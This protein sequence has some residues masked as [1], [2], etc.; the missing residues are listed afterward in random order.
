MKTRRKS[1][2]LL[3]L[4]LMG[5]TSCFEFRIPEIGPII[6]PAVEFGPYEFYITSQ[7]ID[8]NDILEMAGDD[9]AFLDDIREPFP[10]D[11][12]G[13]SDWFVYRTEFRDTL[14]MP[15]EFEI[16]PVSST[17]SQSM[18][19][20]SF[21]ARSISLSDPIEMQE[22]IDLSAIPDGSDIPIDSIIIDPDT[23]Y[24]SFPMLRQ[25]FSAG[26]LEV[27][28]DN[29][30]ACDLGAPISMT[31]YDSLT[32]LP[33]ENDLGDTL[34]LIWSTPISPSTEAME[35]V[36]LANTELPSSVMIITE[37]YVAA[38][39][40]DPDTLTVTP[41]MRTSSFNV[42]GQ[43]SNLEA[44]L[45]EG[46]VDA[47][48]LD[49]S[50]NISFGDA[51]NEPG[52]TVD[53]VYLD[54]THVSIT[55]SN[56]SPL[57][58]KLL[59]NLLS[60]DTSLDM[61]IQAFTTDSLTIPSESSQSFNFTLYNASVDLN[62]DFAYESY[63]RTPS[64]YAE[65]ELSDEFE[66]EFSFYG[67]SPGDPIGIES[68]DAT[69]N[70]M[71][72]SIE[73]TAIDLDLDE[74]LPEIF[75]GIDLAS[76]EMSLDILSSITIPMTLTLELIG[77]KNGGLDSTVISVEQVI[78]GPAGNNHVVIPNAE[79]LINF[80]PEEILFSGGVSLD[81]TGNLPLAQDISISA[82]IAVPIQFIITSPIS[83]P[84]PYIALDKMDSLPNFLDNFEGTVSAAIDNQFRF[85]VSLKIYAAH[86]TSY[87]DNIAFQDSVRTFADLEVPAMDT[88]TQ[89]IVL[90]K[91]DYDFMVSAID[92]NW[93]KMD[94]QLLGREDGL[95]S[96][97][98][99]TD[100]ISVDIFIRAS[101]TLAFNELLPDTTGGE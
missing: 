7:T 37:G 47:Q 82:E 78:T 43:I 40:G 66:I 35:S 36:S 8:F 42:S 14:P 21:D 32:A 63:V 83:F 38:N 55:I 91:E 68:V 53:K 5:V 15:F 23:T 85:G 59:L 99:T 69:F 41:A 65:I 92:S 4:V 80:R 56:S 73:Q 25:H 18:T 88:T 95:A 67:K 20:V 64:Q 71:D 76:V 89:S 60:L 97:F 27:T 94:V 26:T 13:M 31:F 34:R 1:I 86:D 3:L 6:P 33:I 48:S 61:G 72:Q 93:L 22:I 96:T 12:S 70:N 74:M 62:S 29:D 19:M 2:L 44:D 98:V 57:T 45:V 75:D 11:T 10:G 52:L 77:L 50:D 17:I 100:S 87:F 28:I 81:G 9:I 46:N 49:F 30:L 79:N 54:T 39:G 84:L 90:S 24:I 16:D 101:G 58:G 51:I